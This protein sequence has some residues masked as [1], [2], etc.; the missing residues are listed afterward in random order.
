MIVSVFLSLPQYAL[1]IFATE[2]QTNHEGEYGLEITAVF[3]LDGTEKTIR[4]AKNKITKI[5]EKLN[6]TVKH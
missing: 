2:K 3:H 6:E 4:L 5:E 1:D